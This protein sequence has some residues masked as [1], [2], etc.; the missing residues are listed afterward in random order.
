[1]NQQTAAAP[2]GAAQAGAA[3]SLLDEIVEKSKVAKSESEHARAK[4][5]IGDITKMDDKG[6]L[7][8]HR[9][10]TRRASDE[11]REGVAAFLSRRKPHWTL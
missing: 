1:M 3:P 10:A 11:G 4:D 7:T 9:I 2:V 8:A 5:L 6:E